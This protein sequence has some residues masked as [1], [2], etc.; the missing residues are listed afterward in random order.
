MYNNKLVWIVIIAA[1]LEILGFIGITVMQFNGMIDSFSQYL[2]YAELLSFV[3]ALPFFI[4]LLTFQYTQKRYL[5]LSVFS[6][7][8]LLSYFAFFM[9]IYEREYMTTIFAD[10]T[11]V[12]AVAALISSAYVG[13]DDG[14]YKFVKRIFI[15]SAFWLIL[16]KTPVFILSITLLQGFFSG[17]ENHY[18]T[19]YISF[20]IM[21]FTVALI[22]NVFK[23]TVVNRIDFV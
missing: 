10:I 12:G 23:V 6:I 8:T 13:V 15:G 7:L 4:I 3:L 21:Q 18:E 17:A 22:I 19:V 5:L 14:T 1:L 11:F 9:Q 16:F 2:L 20:L